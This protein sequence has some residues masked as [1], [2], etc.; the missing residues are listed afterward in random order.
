MND[1]E[2]LIKSIEVLD[3]KNV[4]DWNYIS[5]NISDELNLLKFINKF[6]KKINWKSLSCCVQIKWTDKFINKY[7]KLL[8][9][10]VISGNNKIPFSEDLILKYIE[11]W[12]W[13]KLSEN[14]SFP[15]NT[16]TINKFKEYIDWENFVRIL[17]F[18]CVKKQLVN[19]KTIL[20][21]KALD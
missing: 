11:K 19:L 12:E 16:Q 4:L 9:F 5:E 13:T 7:E 10:K 8:D 15:M 18:Q 21:G 1:E 3:K 6:F 17:T 14:E 20:I 2:C